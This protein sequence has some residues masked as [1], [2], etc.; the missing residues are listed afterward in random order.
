MKASS[1]LED[2][3]RLAKVSPA[4]VSRVINKTTRVSPDVQARIRAAAEK[5]G[6]DLRKRNKTRLIAFILS[7]R[8]LLYP[9]HS[10]VLLASQAYCAA[11]DYDVVF[12]PLQYSEGQDWDKL[13]LPR[14]FHRADV[15]DGFI[16]SGVN[17]QNLFDALSRTG[18]PFT[19]LGDTVQGNWRASE[20]DVVRI[21]DT[22]G[23]YEV[24]R[25]LQSLGHTKVAFVG[26]TR[27]K[28]FARRH[29]GYLR[30]MQEASLA[31]TVSSVDSENEYEIG[32]IGIKHLLADREKS[33]GAVFAASDAIA[34][35]VYTALRELDIPVPG[36]ISVCGFNDTPDASLLYP[37]LTSVNVFPE[38]IGRSLAELLLAR[39]N[40]ST[41]PPQTRILH[42]RLVKRE[43]C[44]PARTL[45][46]V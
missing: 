6:F 18:L 19:I 29:E 3:A 21:D 13:H 12:L 8:S 43:S 37:P 23:G 35:G 14:I 28:W 9:F 20:Y 15:I 7:N 31:P 1:T 24:T 4:T 27:L 32:F 17:H 2:V 36:A 33:V 10:Q 41:L 46:P 38:L 45:Q 16:A 11:Q 22:D 5:L 42:T 39:I 26:N 25:Y 34:F 44:L 30:A 40:D